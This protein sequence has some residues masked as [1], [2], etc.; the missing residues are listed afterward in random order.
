MA[1]RMQQR[2]GTAAEW[3][4]ANPV[5]AA[6]E[7]GFE[8]DTNKFKFGDGASAW[9]DIAHFSS[10]LDVLG[11]GVPENLDTLVE[12]ANALNNDSNFADTVNELFDTKVNFIIDTDANW[13]QSTELIDSRTL[14][15]SSDT[16]LFKLGDGGSTFSDLPYLATE[17]YVDATV[18]SAISDVVAS[19][20]SLAYGTTIGD[21]TAAEIDYLS[22]VTSAIQSQF[23]DLSTAIGAN[24][25]AS[26]ANAADIATLQEDVLAIPTLDTQING[27]TGIV[28]Q[29]T[30]INASVSGISDDLDTKSPTNSPTFTG[31]VVLP[32]STSVGSVTATEISYLSGV[33]GPIATALDAKL[34][35]VSAATTYAPLADATLTGTV[36]LP[37]TTSVGAVTASEIGHLSGVTSSVQTQLDA[38][39]PTADP[40]FT[41][42]VSG[43]TKAHVG[44]G[45]ASNTADADKPVSTATQTALD[46]KAS[47]TGATFTGDVTVETDLL[48]EGNLTISGTTT[49]INATDLAISDPLIYL[50]S[51]QYAEDVLDVGFLA[52][53]GELGGTEEDHLHA[54]FFRDVSDSAKWKLV[55][56]VPHPVANVVDVTNAVRDTLVVGN[57]EAEGVV[58]A[59]GTQTKMG[60][61]SLTEFVEKTA[62][63]T[64]DDLDLRDGVVEM[65]SASATTFTIPTNATLAWPVGASMDIIQTGSGQVTVSPASGVT[66]NYT[67]GNKL[68]TQWSSCTIMKRAADTWIMYGD[69]TA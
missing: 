41:G 5:L 64:L 4:S 52:A 67:P 24:A 65:N 46:A 29:I 30:A 25:D 3:T 50:A 34:D 10:A 69:L 36:A 43:I 23:S 19:P 33:A 28:D 61:V 58:F 62:S 59:D 47:L 44:L 56:N 26:S 48:V 57:L 31:D 49:T 16:G 35:T 60:V 42:T 1:T 18:N 22:G 63:Y 6:G 27:E 9:N 38:K 8:T 45:E 7:I 12:L 32:S 39:A 17:D 21:V 15:I 55:S 40:T 14:A 20:L 11:E 37:A 68:R 13:A 66:L 54:G 53:T 51:E 2:R